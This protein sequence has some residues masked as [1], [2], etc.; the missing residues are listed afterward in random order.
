MTNINLYYFLK[1]IKINNILERSQKSGN[2]KV[3]K[4]QLIESAETE[5]LASK[6]RRSRDKKCQSNRMVEAGINLSFLP[7]LLGAD[8]ILAAEEWKMSLVG[9]V[10]GARRYLHK[11]KA[12]IRSRWGSCFGSSDGKGDLSFQIQ[13]ER[14]HGSG[15]GTWPLDL[16]KQPLVL[17]PWSPEE[18]YGLGCQISWTSKSS[19]KR[20]HP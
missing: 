20:R 14:G 5:G 18:N 7:D 1:D 11:L 15:L 13:Q 9:L 6:R 4:G 3:E 10:F 12:F 19:E 2:R 16:R 8:E 17:Q